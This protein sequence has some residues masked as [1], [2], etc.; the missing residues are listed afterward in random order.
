MQGIGKHHQ[1]AQPGNKPQDV[2]QAFVAKQWA[3]RIIKGKTK[4]KNRQGN[5]PQKGELAHEQAITQRHQQ[6]HPAEKSPDSHRYHHRDEAGKL[7]LHVNI[8]DLEDHHQ[9]Q[10]GAQKG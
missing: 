10:E 8:P 2:G 6:P 9:R 5:D 4:K 7:S 1:D 3:S